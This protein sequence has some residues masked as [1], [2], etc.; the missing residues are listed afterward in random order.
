MTLDMDLRQPVK[1][2]VGSAELPHLSIRSLPAVDSDQFAE[3]ASRGDSDLSEC[4][5]PY[6]CLR[7]H[8][9]E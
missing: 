6:D 4:A 2:T 9:N 1:Q 3:P 8:E 5:C 7:D